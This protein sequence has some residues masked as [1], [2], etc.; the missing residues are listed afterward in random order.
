MYYCSIY[1]HLK[2]VLEPMTTSN[3]RFL[4]DKL[5]RTSN[6]ARPFARYSIL[7]ISY[8][9]IKTAIASICEFVLIIVLYSITIE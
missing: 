7:H 4:N 1:V 8:N 5:F 3:D 9:P 2:I 6:I